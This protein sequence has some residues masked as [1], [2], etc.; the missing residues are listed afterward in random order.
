[1]LKSYSLVSTM[2]VRLPGFFTCSRPLRW[3]WYLQ[4]I[5]ILGALLRQSCVAFGHCFVLTVWTLKQSCEIL[6]CC[7]WVIGN[8]FRDWEHML[9]PSFLHLK[10]LAS[11]GWGSQPLKF[12]LGGHRTAHEVWKDYFAKVLLFSLDQCIHANVLL[13]SY[14]MESCWTWAIYKA[15]G[16]ADQNQQ[17][18]R[19]IVSLTRNGFDDQDLW[20]FAVGSHVFRSSGSHNKYLKNSLLNCRWMVWYIWWMHFDL[21]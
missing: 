2:W 9:L 10:S 7:V 12:D 4:G 15:E 18:G 20:C 5:S 11:A 14:L 1:M 6:V 21:A 8:C 19:T 3:V 16:V 17:S 13:C